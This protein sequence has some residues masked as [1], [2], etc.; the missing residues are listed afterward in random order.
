MPRLD[1]QFYA[2]SALE[3]A[4]LLLGKVLV[5]RTADGT[6]RRFSITETECYLG[7]EDTAC[8]ASKGRTPRTETLYRRGGCAYIYLCYGMHH[9]LNAVTGEQDSPQ[10]VLI[11][12]GRD[13]TTGKLYDGPAKLTKAMGID[14]RLNGEDLIRSAELWIEDTG[15][16][17]AYTTAPRVGIDY[18]SEP[19]RSIHWRFILK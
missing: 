14:K 12:G 5:H 7:E 6:E 8:H 19:Y 4:P 1:E 15:E 9:L 10:A 18:A 2:L 13:L 3:A 16:R 17:P 11:R